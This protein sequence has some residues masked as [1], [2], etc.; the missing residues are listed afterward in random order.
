[1]EEEVRTHKQ[2]GGGNASPSISAGRRTLNHWEMRNQ[3]AI[4][5]FVL[6]LMLC[7]A[8]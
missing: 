1:M 4:W 5:D 7:N 3:C 2:W 8:Y 6:E